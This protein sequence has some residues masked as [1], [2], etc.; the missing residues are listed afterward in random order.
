MGWTSTHALEPSFA[1]SLLSRYARG[2]NTP[3]RRVT[4]GFLEAM[5]AHPPKPFRSSVVDVS[6]LHFLVWTDASVSKTTGDTQLGTLIQFCSSTQIA[7]LKTIGNY[8]N[9][10]LHKSAKYKRVCRSSGQAELAALSLGID[11]VCGLILTL[12]G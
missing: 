4:R 10:V 3:A 1:F 2:R 5:V 9:I 12:K 7:T 11:E 8:D 6:D